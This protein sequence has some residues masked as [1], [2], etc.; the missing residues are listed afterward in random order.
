MAKDK[1]ILS[2]V[3]R[4]GVRRITALLLSALVLCLLA[5]CG[6]DKAE[7]KS[8]TGAADVGEEVRASAADLYCHEILTFTGAFVEDGSNEQVENV[9][10][11]LIQ[12]Q[13]DEFLD[14]AVVT[15]D[16]GDKTA[17]FVV[18]GLPSGATATVLET[19]RLTLDGTE[20][21]LEPEC[22]YAFKQDAITST[23][24][25]TVT[26]EG[27]VLTAEN[28]TEGDLKNVCIYY[29]NLSSDG[30]YLG[31][32]TYMLSFGDMQSGERVE[33]SAAHFSERSQIV[34]YSFQTE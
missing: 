11:I 30:T 15:Y 26:A 22:T 10:A 19:D 29:K 34:R 1:R 4:A 9:A 5:G 28:N 32:I 18:T 16:L 7:T 23:E 12:N 24:D 2:S 27:N 33:K 31:G 25:V 3:P 14:R 20:T 8:T 13:S 17:T 21:F 6:S